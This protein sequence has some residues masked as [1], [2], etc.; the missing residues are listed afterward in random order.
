MAI[1]GGSQRP[2]AIN[3]RGE[4]EVSARG[5]DVLHL[6][7]INK[8][9]A[10]TKAERTALGL[11]GLLPAAV[12]TIEQQAERLYD[13]YRELPNDLAKNQ[14]LAALADRNETLF[15]YFLG[16]HIVEIASNFY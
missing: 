14:F 13:M 10:F 7:Q 16:Q 6:P 8:G 11:T 1:A 12:V 3:A 5:S 4:L 15:F 2:Y 9:T